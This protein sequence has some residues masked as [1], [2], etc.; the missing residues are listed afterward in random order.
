MYTINGLIQ[1]KLCKNYKNEILPSE[2]IN[3]Y[4]Q[5]IFCSSDCRKEYQDSKDLLKKVPEQKQLS[6][7]QLKYQKYREQELKYKKEYYKL[8]RIRLIEKAT[9]YK[10]NKKLCK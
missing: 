9:L 5:I 8:N 4:T 7:G 6:K 10:L 1:Y 3:N 2:F